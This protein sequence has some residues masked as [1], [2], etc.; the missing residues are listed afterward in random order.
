VA[1][2][3]R[4][5]VGRRARVRAPAG[6][7]E[8]FRARWICGSNFCQICDQCSGWFASAAA[9]VAASRAHAHATTTATLSVE[10]RHNCWPIRRDTYE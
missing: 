6:I 9:A 7:L 10:L 5:A 3:A 2:R 4:A 1:V 8:C